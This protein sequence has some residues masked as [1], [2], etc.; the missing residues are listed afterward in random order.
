MV[1]EKFSKNEKVRKLEKM[2]IELGRARDKL[3]EGLDKSSEVREFITSRKQIIRIKEKPVEKVEEL[4]NLKNSLKKIQGNIDR[5]HLNEVEK[6][7]VKDIIQ[8]EL[9]MIDKKVNTQKRKTLPRVK[10]IKNMDKSERKKLLQDLKELNKKYNLYNEIDFNEFSDSTESLILLKRKIIG[11]KSKSK[12]KI[13]KTQKEKPEEKEAEKEK[14]EEKVQEKETENLEKKEVKEGLEKVQK[15]KL[16]EPKTEED[17][18]KIVEKVQEKATEN[19]EKKEVKEGSELSKAEV[20]NKDEWKRLRELLEPQIKKEKRINEVLEKIKAPNLNNIL[21][22]SLDDVDKKVIEDFSEVFS[23]E[24]Y[25]TLKRLD[26]ILPSSEKMYFGKYKHRDPD[27]IPDDYV[28]WYV[29]NN[30]INALKVFGLKRVLKQYT[31]ESDAIIKT[32]IAETS[33]NPKGFYLRIPLKYDDEKKLYDV[34]FDLLEEALIK[35]SGG[36]ISKIYR[37]DYRNYAKRS[38][39]NIITKKLDKKNKIYFMDI[40]TKDGVVQVPVIFNEKQDTPGVPPALMKDLQRELLSKGI[41]LEYKPV[42]NQIEFEKIKYDWNEKIKLRPYQQM[43]VDNAVKKGQGVVQVATGGGKTEIATRLIHDIQK[44]AVFFVHTKDLF[45]QAKSRIAKNLKLNEGEIGEIKAGAVKKS[46]NG[47]T[48]A[49]IQSISSILAAPTLSQ[50]IRKIEKEIRQL[51]GEENKDE[52]EAL[53]QQLAELKK[54]TPAE[55]EKKKNDLNEILNNTGI[56]IFDECQHIPARTFYRVARS[57]RTDHVYGLSATP[58]RDDGLTAVI[59]AGL[60]GIVYPRINSKYLIDEGYLVKPEIYFAQVYDDKLYP[61]LKKILDGDYYDDLNPAEQELLQKVTGLSPEDLKRKIPKVGKGAAGYMFVKKAVL[62]S[63]ERNDYIEDIASMLDQGEVSTLL[64]V[65]QIDQGE[66][67]K[68]RLKE[69]AEKEVWDP[70]TG[71]LRKY[72]PEA[73]FLNSRVS[74]KK[75]KK[76]LEDF[77]NGK[78]DVLIATSL[79]DEGLDIPSMKALML[80]GGGKSSIKGLQR[81]G[82]VIR[83]SKKDIDPETGRIKESEDD[84]EKPFGLVVDI[85]DQAPYF[86]KQAKTR[87]ELYEKEE[88]GVEE[89]SKSEKDIIKKKVKRLAKKPEE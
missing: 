69:R 84:L 26:E 17:V 58:W 59:H 24:K 32:M 27:K 51:K 71:E 19:L 60:G 12:K 88:F 18:K 55:F 7:K 10:E 56:A 45:N 48:V 6:K 31:D 39:Q 40:K 30:P 36:T 73:E 81:V 82:R 52:R 57:L 80:T 86:E 54:M 37:Q 22:D 83:V 29:S 23:R 61:I 68:E 65:D 34:D 42:E 9:S 64:L 15:E 67:I 72:K 14:I 89:I 8:K 38:L 33:K 70:R 62:R 35:A 16:E 78:I 66:L 46:K 41:Y 13:K 20:K 25:D 4:F 2:M 47:V 75:R 74:D 5:F 3:P 11:K 1:E 77:K 79:A 63:P 28:E 21:N 50:A 76:I 49:M 43:I 87:K 53:K 85:F 44:P